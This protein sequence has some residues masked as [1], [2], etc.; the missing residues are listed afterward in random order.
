MRCCA[1]SF[2]VLIAVAL[3]LCERTLRREKFKRNI[4]SVEMDLFDIER[5]LLG[6]P[7]LRAERIAAALETVCSPCHVMHCRAHSC[8]WLRL[9]T[10]L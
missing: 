7:F 4:L 6:D 5:Q 9:L 10:V 2:A 8:A 1:H 3:Q